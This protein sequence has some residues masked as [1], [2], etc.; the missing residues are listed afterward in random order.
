M[1]LHK[2]WLLC[3]K[4]LFKTSYRPKCGAAATALRGYFVSPLTSVPPTCFLLNTPQLRAR[5]L[6]KYEMKAGA[7]IISA[8]VLLLAASCVSAANVKSLTSDNF[9]STTASGTWFIKL[10][11]IIYS[12]FQ[13]A[14]VQRSVLTPLVRRPKFSS[15]VMPLG[16]DFAKYVLAFPILDSL[17]QCYRCMPRLFCD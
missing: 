2:G 4:I 9:D 12:R 16:A 13:D 3:N 17:S 8:L 1:L 6:C 5:T 10:Y 11:V 7:L 15:L 14:S